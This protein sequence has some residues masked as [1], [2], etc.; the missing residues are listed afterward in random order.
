MGVRWPCVLL[1]CCTT[2]P[3]S[4]H[5]LLRSHAC[6]HVGR[7]P[8][9]QQLHGDPQYGSRDVWEEASAAASAR[10]RLRH[11]LLGGVRGA[12]QQVQQLQRQV[13]ARPLA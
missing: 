3:P 1:D 12:R 2:R 13:G 11:R 10:R 6:N 9:L 4:A 7:L 5:S 8:E